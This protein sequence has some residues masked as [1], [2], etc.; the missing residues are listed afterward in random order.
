M[1]EY[2]FSLEHG[3]YFEDAEEALFDLLDYYEDEDD[4]DEIDYDDRKSTA[5]LS[6]DDLEVEIELDDEEVSVW[7]KI[8]APSLRREAGDIEADLE[9]NVRDFFGLGRPRR[10]RQRTG[11]R[12]RGG[13]VS[14]H[15][16]VEVVEVVESKRVTAAIIAFFLGGLG[17]HKF[18][19]GKHLQGALYLFFCW[20]GIPAIIALIEFIMYLVMSDEDFIDKYQTED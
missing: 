16:R 2:E 7:F 15:E 9:D 17:I 6:N 18:Y 5:Y 1:A 4:F 3:L 20:T 8:H 14:R 12:R 11:S 19:L 13:S 10:T